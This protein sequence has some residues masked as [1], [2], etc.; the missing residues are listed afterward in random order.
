MF[1]IFFIKNEVDFE[2]SEF[3]SHKNKIFKLDVLPD[4]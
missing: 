2:N 3:V 4:Y 1:N